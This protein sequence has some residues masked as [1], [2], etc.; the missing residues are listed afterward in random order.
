MRKKK[1]MP[2]YGKGTAK[3]P[4]KKYGAGG[5]AM[6]AFLKSKMKKKTKKKKK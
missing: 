3:T 5:K 1:T 6:P 2:K 4:M